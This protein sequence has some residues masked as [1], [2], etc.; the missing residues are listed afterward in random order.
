VKLKKGNKLGM[1][2]DVIKY[3]VK[4][5]DESGFETIE[6]SF[7]ELHSIIS[8]RLRDKLNDFLRENR[9][10]IKHG[11]EYIIYPFGRIID[12][13]TSTQIIMELKKWFAP[14]N[15]E[16]DIYGNINIV[17]VTAIPK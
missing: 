5:S 11:N 15:D 14:E 13:S 4:F 3:R 7:D 2:H 9:T 10:G 17:T 6:T 16:D 12:T 8:D 1:E